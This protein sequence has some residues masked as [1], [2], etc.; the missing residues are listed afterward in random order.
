MAGSYQVLCQSRFLLIS[1]WSKWSH[2]ATLSCKAGWE[3]LWAAFP[4][5][6]GE[7]HKRRG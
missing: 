3:S 5:S 4:V 2:I 6:V 7:R 1:H